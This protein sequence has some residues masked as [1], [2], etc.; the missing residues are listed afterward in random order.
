LVEW[1]ERK[2]AS[3]GNELQQEISTIGR[4]IPFS[5]KET[6][7]QRRPRAASE[8]QK[9]LVDKGK[10]KGNPRNLPFCSRLLCEIGRLDLPPCAMV[11]GKHP[12]RFPLFVYFVDNP[13]NVR[14]LT[15]KP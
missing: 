8:N 6:F 14:L 1:A 5:R 11:N 4:A 12:H 10:P 9:K 2:S 13:I 15:L 3:A 7:R